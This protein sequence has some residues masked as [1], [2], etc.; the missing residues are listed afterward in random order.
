M[1]DSCWLDKPLGISGR[2]VYKNNDSIETRIVDFDDD[3]CIIPNLAIHLNREINNGFAYNAQEDLLPI[4]GLSEKDLFIDL[5]NKTKKENEEILSYDLFLFN[6][7]K[8]K[9]LGVNKDFITSPKIR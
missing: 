6:R 9:Y 1:I 7:E 5:I 8:A 2:I 4:I 3:L